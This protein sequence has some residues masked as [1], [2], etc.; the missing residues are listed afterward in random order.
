[1]FQKFPGRPVV[2]TAL[3]LQEAW[4]QSLVVELRSCKLCGMTKKKGKEY[5]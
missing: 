3:L 1:M 5:F 4:V 2:R